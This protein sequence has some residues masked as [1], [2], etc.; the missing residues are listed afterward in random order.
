MIDASRMSFAGR[1]VTPLMYLVLVAV[2]EVA[3]RTLHI[4]AWILPAPSAIVAASISWAPD[5]LLNT[6]VTL[7]ETVVGFVLALLVSVPVAVVIGFSVAGRR[8][9][10]PIVLGLQS[11]PKVALAPLVMLWLGLAEWPKIIIVVL[12]CFFPIL[13]NLVAGFE[14]VPKSSLDLM[15]S[16]RA[17]PLMT[18]RRLYIPAAAPHLFTGCKI[19]ITLAVIGAVIAEFVAAQNGLGYLIL[20][21]TAQ[22]QTPLAFAAIIILTVISIVLFHAIELLERR[23]VTWTP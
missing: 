13:V 22:S 14:A 4:P 2:W 16:L 23:V 21:S 3:T 12:V 10:Y 6:I 1:A 5:L 20:M 7:R 11:V 19:A 8:F 17:S 15:Y 9:I 18:F